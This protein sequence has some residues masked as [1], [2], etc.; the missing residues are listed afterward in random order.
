MRHLLS[1]LAALLDSQ[2]GDGAGEVQAGV[3]ADAVALQP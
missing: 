3:E 2:A 1:F